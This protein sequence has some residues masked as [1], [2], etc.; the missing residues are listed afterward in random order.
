MP[1][2]LIVSCHQNLHRKVVKLVTTLLLT[3]FNFYVPKMMN[4]TYFQQ[5]NREIYTLNRLRK[6]SSNVMTMSTNMNQRQHEY[7]KTCK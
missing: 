4:D 1:I 7:S 3:T 6:L 5:V 2:L